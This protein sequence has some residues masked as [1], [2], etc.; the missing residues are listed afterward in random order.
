MD[1][2]YHNSTLVDSHRLSDFAAST[3][4]FGNKET[5]TL[6]SD[7]IQ[8]FSVQSLKIMLKQDIVKKNLMIIA[9]V[10]LCTTIDYILLMFSIEFN[11]TYE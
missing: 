2:H 4:N 9:A 8:K 6:A 5:S 7:D 3:Q 10:W 1:F 11:S